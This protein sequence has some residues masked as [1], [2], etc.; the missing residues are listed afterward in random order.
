LAF[1]KRIDSGDFSKSRIDIVACSAAK[2]HSEKA[3]KGVK[4]NSEK[5]I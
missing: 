1:F 4:K 3:I 5:K 2:N